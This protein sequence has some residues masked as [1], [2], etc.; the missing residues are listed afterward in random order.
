VGT[1]CFKLSGGID[2]STVSVQTS[3][4]G[5]REPKIEEFTFETAEWISFP[6]D[7]SSQ[8]EIEI[9]TVGFREEEGSLTSFPSREIHFSFVAN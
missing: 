1:W 2:P 3:V 7:C 4:V 8:E 6:H 9:Q 5:G